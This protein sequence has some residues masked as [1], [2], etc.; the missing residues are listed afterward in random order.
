MGQYL[1]LKKKYN[2]ERLN[3]LPSKLGTKEGHLTKL[4]HYYSEDSS[5]CNE[6][7]VKGRELEKDKTPLYMT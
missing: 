7:Q 2:G 5:L 1:N 4:T 6:A 3:S